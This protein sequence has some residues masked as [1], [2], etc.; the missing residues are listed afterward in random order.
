MARFMA[1]GRYNMWE[2]QEENPNR[3]PE[4][5]QRDPDRPAADFENREDVMADLLNKRRRQLRTFIGQIAKS[6]SRNMYAG[7]VRHATSLEWVYNK[8]REDYDIQTKG[9]HF[10]NI[11]D[12]EY[13]KETKTPAGFYNKYRTVILNNIGRRNEVIHWNQDRELPGDEVIGPLFE[14]VV[15]M[16]V[17]QII[18]P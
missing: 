5:H 12:L 13:N 6:A 2:S 17:L 15:L 9:I 16:N 10:L 11:V 18:D 1:D 3:I 7:I 8:V 4:L 14:D